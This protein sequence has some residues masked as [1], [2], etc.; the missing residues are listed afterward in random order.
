MNATHYK[1]GGAS[2][3]VINTLQPWEADLILN[4]RLWCEGP[5]GQAQVWNSF[6]T[7]LPRGTAADEMHAFE[8]LVGA[9]I[10]HA[11]RPLVRHS[12]GC[13]CVGADESV[14]AHLVATA[15][16][17][18]LGEASL[19]ATLL[20]TAAHAEQVA[21][22]AGQVGQSARQMSQYHAH[23]TDALSGVVVHLHSKTLQ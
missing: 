20:V 11:H 9:L 15:S 2:V 18:D 13:A 19:I 7:S 23:K 8:A 16:D 1:R 10:R 17:G 3:G 14:F 4:L 5:V 6:A 22:L 21:L 12:V